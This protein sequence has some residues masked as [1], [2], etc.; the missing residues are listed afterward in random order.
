MRRY[1]SFLLSN[2][3]V[4]EGEL[5]L[6]PRESRHLL[7]VLR[8]RPGDA[9]EVLD[10][11]GTVR[12]GRF[13]GE[14]GGRARI[15]VVETREAPR[16]APELVLMPAVAKGKAMDLILRVATEI[17][18]ARIVP[19]FTAHGEV[20]LDEARA[21][22]RR[23][24]WETVMVEA[25][26][27]CGLPWLPD[28]T[29]PRPLEEAFSSLPEDAL[30]IVASLEE[31]GRP[32]ADLLDPAAAA[33]GVVFAVGPEGDFSPEEYAL[34]REQGF[35]PARLGAQVLRAQTACAYVLSVADQILR[36]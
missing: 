8:V 35:R 31:G 25:C 34:L 13:A 28:L 12:E 6:D 21:V 2:S 27:Q 4:A 30:R 10:G 32:L 17:G 22:E 33:A 11:R 24:K 29:V 19:V 5:F 1:R 9:V 23:G 7:R 18:A 16:L 3:G 26:K 15:E 20:R 14:S 36:V